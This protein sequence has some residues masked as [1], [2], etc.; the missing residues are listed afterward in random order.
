[1]QDVLTREDVMIEN[2][3]LTGLDSF[4]YRFRVAE[5]MSAPLLTA[6]AETSLLDGVNQMRAANVS[7]LIATPSDGSAYGIV[8]ERD[9]LKALAAHGPEGLNR[10]LKEVMTAPVATVPADAFV[11]VAIGRMQRKNY[12]HLVAVD[13]AGRAVGMVT[14][15]ALLRLRSRS[16]LAL[17]DAMGEA[18]DAAAMG[19][20]W[21]QLPPLAAALRKD[22]VSAIGVARIVA[23]AMRDMVGR[24]A[25]LAA[26]AL[27]ADPSW[28]VAPAPYAVLILG[29]GGRGET[30]LAP[31]QDTA[32]VYDGPAN[33]AAD[34][35]FA[36]LGRRLSDMLN[37]AGLPYC[38]GGVMASQPGWRRS[39]DQWKETINDWIDN[40]KPDALLNVDIFFDMRA[41]YGDHALA[42]RLH[43]YALDR[44]SAAPLFL[45]I[46]GGELERHGPPLGL[47]GRFVTDDK[48]RIDMKLH[49]TLPV[50]LAARVLSLRLNSTA[51]AT[52]DRYEAAERAGEVTA[53]E[54]RELTAAHDF[55]AGLILDQQVRDFAAGRATSNKIEVKGLAVEVRHRLKD[56]F[57]RVGKLSWV[58]KDGSQA[59]GAAPIG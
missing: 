25:E 43:E 36:E 31:D 1:M 52:A 55:L 47:F 32:I 13:I 15:R 27:I 7:S 39:F 30:L 6:S 14:A 51:T 45:R 48:G 46:L 26:Q 34:R 22:G 37:E 42:E 44:A 33:D 28:G 9:V 38:D 54:R 2:A 4:P 57:A 5:I 35:W 17:G 53:E 40:P 18:P 24:C 50:T 12:R 56:A 11:Y 16:A 10:P 41:A 8:T 3:G 20:L 49:G 58:L 21:K 19:V 23:G 29:S 59:I